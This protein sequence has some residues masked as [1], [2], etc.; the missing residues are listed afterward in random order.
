MNRPHHGFFVEGPKILQAAPATGDDQAIDRQRQLV[1]RG[2]GRSD[3]GGRAVALHPRGHDDHIGPPP[4]PAKDL[5]EIVD[6]RAGR[7]GDHGN[8]PHERRQ[9]PLPPRVEE[10]LAGQFLAKLPQGQL[11]GPH[12]LGLNTLNDQLVVAP[13]GVDIDPTA[14]NHFQSVV[15][16]EPHPRGHVAP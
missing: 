2:D 9:R 12:A 14:A 10:T 11:E 1:D 8:P 6:R 5:Q 15:Q 13:R 16:I 7:A 3:L 4:P